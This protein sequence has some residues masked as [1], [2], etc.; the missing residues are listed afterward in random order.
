MHSMS[1]PQVYRENSPG[2]NAKPHQN[3]AATGTPSRF[4]TAPKIGQAKIEIVAG[5][6]R[7]IRTRISNEIQ[8]HFLKAAADAAPFNTALKTMAFLPTR[9]QLSANSAQLAFFW[10]R[11]RGRVPL[12]INRRQNQEN[13]QG[14]CRDAVKIQ[15]CYSLLTT[16]AFGC[17][18]NATVD[19]S[20]RCVNQCSADRSFHPYE[21]SYG[22]LN[23]TDYRSTT[24]SLCR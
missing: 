24:G 2:Q 17:P 7:P 6:S 8:V 19:G 23:A 12:R 9:A 3:S 5:N 15:G 14:R 20:L 10:H 16:V 4:Q 1:D 21:T 13:A 22:D 11:P 18:V